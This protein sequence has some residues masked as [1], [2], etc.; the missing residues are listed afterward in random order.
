MSETRKLLLAIAAIGV[1]VLGSVA[2]IYSADLTY[3]DQSV[4][5]ADGQGYYVYLRAA[6]LDHDLTMRKTGA[7]SFGGDP[8]YSSGVNWVHN[9]GGHSVPL[10]QVGIGARDGRYWLHTIPSDQ[11]TFHQY[12][13]SFW[14]Y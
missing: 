13:A 14:R 9:S 12:L 10:D 3:N 2:W 6:P 4:I 11:T 8:A 1:L 7:R 5:R